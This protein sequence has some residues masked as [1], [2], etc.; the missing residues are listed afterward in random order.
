[1]MDLR[2][3]M[4][5]KS[6]LIHSDVFQYLESMPS[7]FDFIFIGPPQYLS[8]W[9]K[10]LNVLDEHPNFLKKDGWAILQCDPS[11][12]RENKYQNLVQSDQRKYGSVLLTF[13]EKKSH[14]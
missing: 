5:E 10:S 8:L 12:Y 4:K 11:E 7:T 14:G 1:M 2:A 13:F 6:Q 9:S 3:R